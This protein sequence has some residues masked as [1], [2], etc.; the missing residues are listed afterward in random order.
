MNCCVFPWLLRET[1]ADI[2]VTRIDSSI[3]GVTVSVV[4]PDLLPDVA[5]IVVVPTPTDAA[6]PIEPVALLIVATSV[7]E[8]LQTD[9]AVI[10]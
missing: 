4:D 8:E 5:V 9:D 6:S 10:S 2:G 1:V 3:A 7:F